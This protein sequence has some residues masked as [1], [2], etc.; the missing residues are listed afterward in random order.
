MLLFARHFQIF[1]F[2][3]L[4]IKM[5]LY[6]SL[7]LIL[8]IHFSVYSIAQTDSCSLTI[9]LLTMS[10]GEELYSTF[11][12]SAMRVKD[13]SGKLD[14]VF[15]YGTFEFGPDFYWQF[16]RGKLNYFLSVQDFPD[17]L[18]DY[19]EEHRGIIEQSLQLTCEEKHQL[20]SALQEN[21]QEA[22]RFYKYDFLFDNCTTRLRDIV[23]KNSHGELKSGN[24]LPPKVPTFRNLLYDYLDA[25][26]EYW[27]KLGID[28]LL[29]SKLD[30]KVTNEQAMFLPDYLLKAFDSASVHN[31]PL[32]SSK[33]SDLSY[34]PLQ[35]E[36]PWVR[37]E[38]I[39]LILLIVIVS[40]QLIKNRTA[41]LILLIF[42]YLFFPV[43]G[44][45]GVLL[46]FMWFGTDHIVCSNNYNLLWA[47]PTHLPVVFV[48][49][50]R[51]KWIV[52]YFRIVFFISLLLLVCW[53]I[54]PQQ[55]NT[56]I[57]PVLG[58]ILLRSF[59]RSKRQNLPA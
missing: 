4:Q 55:Y 5:K 30:K 11:G 18:K 14:I 31:K 20:F 8:S 13:S 28:I 7:L 24:I 37:P 12:H 15:N 43:L 22:N 21:M 57:A 59:Y 19:Q 27:S 52:M 58:I 53:F 35:N 50:R 16:T 44:L 54:L 39:F 45:L 40:L 3:N 49:H 17:F 32:V 51:R 47:L 23:A 38:I 26:K 1:K 34:P 56:T 9:S 36:S 46:L 48:M 2:S 10:P 29:G 6:R 33:I 25:G 41:K 42:D